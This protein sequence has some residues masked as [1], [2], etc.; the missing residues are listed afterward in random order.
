MNRRGFLKLLGKVAG[1]GAAVA[2]GAKLLPGQSEKTEAKPKEAKS[3]GFTPPEKPAEPKPLVREIPEEHLKL[4]KGVAEDLD[5]ESFEEL[6]KFAEEVINAKQLP[7]LRL[8][9]NE[10]VMVQHEIT[11][12]DGTGTTND[13]KVVLNG[14][15][16]N[17]GATSG[18]FWIDTSEKNLKF[19]TV[20]GVD[21][22]EY[23]VVTH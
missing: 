10:P 21:G 2:A 12:T 15:T 16:A 23:Y 3:K 8:D 19:R 9:A 7:T 6:S 14:T 1:A 4:A 11:V 20:D 18:F 13:T 22:G 17:P 5:L